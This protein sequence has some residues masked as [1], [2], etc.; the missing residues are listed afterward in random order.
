[1]KLIWH[2]SKERSPDEVCRILQSF[3]NGTG[4]SRPWDFDDFISVPIKN[5]ALDKIR[6]QFSD[7]S[8]EFPD[9]DTTKP[10]PPKG[11]SELQTFIDEAK[12][13][14]ISSGHSELLAKQ[15]TP[16]TANKDA[17]NSRGK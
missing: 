6:S 15:R 16:N 13:L 1:M 9:W 7:L 10:F 4:Q 3:V 5:P 8:D 2:P 14:E 12:R 17:G 11:M